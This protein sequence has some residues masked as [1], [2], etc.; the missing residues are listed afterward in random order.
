MEGHLPRGE[1][2]TGFH[3]EQANPMDYKIEDFIYE[4]VLDFLYKALIDAPESALN[5][6]IVCPDN[7]GEG[8]W[9]PVQVL[10]NKAWGEIDVEGEIEAAVYKITSLWNAVAATA[11]DFFNSSTIRFPCKHVTLEE[12]SQTI[13]SIQVADPQYIRA[14]AIWAF[15]EGESKVL[16]ATTEMSNDAVPVPI[17]YFFPAFLPTPKWEDWSDPHTARIAVPTGWEGLIFNWVMVK[18]HLH[19]DNNQLAMRYAQNLK[20]EMKQYG[21]F[22]DTPLSHAGLGI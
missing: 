12:F 2:L 11:A 18:W 9:V 4:S 17:T 3:P 20:R 21:F 10:T 5:E 1:L 16:F 14:N 13:N 19:R 8:T 22:I 6:L 15:D 7:T